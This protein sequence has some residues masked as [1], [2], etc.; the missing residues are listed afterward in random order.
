[1][2]NDSSLH[3]TDDPGVDVTA[4]SPLPDV[5][6]AGDDSQPIVPPEPI[7]ISTATLASDAAQVAGTFGDPRTLYEQA[8]DVYE[9]DAHPNAIDHTADADADVTADSSANSVAG[10]RRARIYDS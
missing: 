3:Q 9:D 2:Q 7:D 5:P 8:L 1:M 4:D 6:D 10:A